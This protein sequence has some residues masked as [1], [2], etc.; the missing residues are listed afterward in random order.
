MTLRVTFKD[1]I[2]KKHNVH[3]IDTKQECTFEKSRVASETSDFFKGFYKIVTSLKVKR[4]KFSSP[5]LRK[6]F[7]DGNRSGI[8]L[9]SKLFPFLFI[10]VLKKPEIG[11]KSTLWMPKKAKMFK[12][13]LISYILC[14]YKFRLLE[15][16]AFNNSESYFP[17]SLVLL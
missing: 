1:N 2:C 6:Y 12:F 11:L 16:S 5:F 14:L 7:K 4:L 3:L 9:R 10:K 17:D 15:K 13:K 8:P